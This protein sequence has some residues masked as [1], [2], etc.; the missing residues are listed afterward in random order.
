MKQNKSPY[1]YLEAYYLFW[2]EPYLLAELGEFEL[3]VLHWAAKQKVMTKEL[4]VQVIS[5]LSAKK[6][7]S[8][9]LYHI[10]E[11]CYEVSPEEEILSAICG[12]LIK[13]QCFTPSYH[14]WYEQAIAANL[15][16]TGLY[17]AYLML[18]LIH[19]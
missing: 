3:S 8:K 19:I 12:Y 5:M 4:G 1:F 9:L 17:E 16:I 7:F 10:L 2:Q 15:R 14:K 13:S 11:Q 6:E 18:S